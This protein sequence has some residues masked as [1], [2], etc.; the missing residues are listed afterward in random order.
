MSRGIVKAMIFSVVV[1][2]C[3][4]WTIKKAER[5]RVGAFNLWCWGRLLR[6]PWTER[7]SNQ[8]NLKEINPEYSL[9]G[10]CWNWSS[11]TLATWCEEPTH[12]K[13]PWCWERLRAGREGGDRGWDS[14]IIS[15]TQWTWV[16]A[17]PGRWCRTETPGMLQSMGLQIVGHDWATEQQHITLSPIFKKKKKIP[18]FQN[19]HH[20]SSILVV[21]KWGGWVTSVRHDRESKEA[22]GIFSALSGRHLT[23]SISLGQSSLGSSRKREHLLPQR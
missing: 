9:E 15:S 17:N 16:W 5:Q 14:W 22:L 23:F 12:W 20:C 7:R 3:E 10:L 19:T 6:V 1:Y 2:R 18:I 11:N 13:R 4:S 8:S 21:N